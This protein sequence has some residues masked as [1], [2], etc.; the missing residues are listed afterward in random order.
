MKK[1]FD[2]ADKKTL[3]AFAHVAWGHK[4]EVYLMGFIA[5]SAI[6]INVLV[7]FATS[8]VLANLAKQEGQHWTYVYFFIAAAITGIVTNRIGFGA[9]MRIAAKGGRDLDRKVL[10]MLLK[11]SVG[12]HANNIGGKLVSD[13][14][15]YSRSYM[16]VQNAIIIDLVPFAISILIGI[17]I[18]AFSSVALAGIML[19]MSC[20]II[21]W[22]WWT[23]VSRADLRVRRK[24]AQREV[25][26][27][28]GDNIT[29]VFTVKSFANEQ[30]ELKQHTKLGD[31]LFSIRVKDWMEVARDGSNRHAALLTM[32]LLFVLYL[33]HA[34]STN[35]DLLGVSIFAF[36]YSVT[37]TNRL[38]QINTIVQHL[39][40]GLMEAA[41]MT[42]YLEQTIEIIDDPNATSLTVDQAEIQF[43]NVNFQ[44]AD[45]NSAT[46]IFSNFTL[47]IKPGERIGL[48]GPSGGGKSTFMKLLLR[49][50]E[51]TSGTITIDGQDITKVS[52]ESLR[53]SL[54]YVSQEPLLFHR[55]VAEN[56]AYASNGTD[57]DSIRHAA[58]KAHALDFIDSLSNG[59]ETV[60]GERG[61]KL[62]GGQ[63][64]RIAIARTVLKDAPILL[65][66][67]A[68]SAL[69]SE[70][71]KHIQAALHDLMKNKT[72]VVIAHRLSTINQ[73]DR[74]I[75]IDNGRIIEEGTHSQLLKKQGLYAKLWAHQSGG[76]IEDEPAVR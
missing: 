9:L 49:F 13:A 26:A 60:V 8:N 6:C 30:A 46:D 28:I 2:Q 27:H 19:A 23:S 55:T 62:S 12:F 7:P 50:E 76:F 69:D 10:D 53:K 43:S 63:R 34:T 1:L 14:I 67:E 45:N 5:V 16:Q 74:I 11:R 66:D 40:N 32:Q 29:N 65:L 17:G 68:T 47:T 56:I 41:P 52:Q 21:C 4:R 71:E 48:V 54:G 75:V 15:D 20:L 33:V 59:F 72:T 64:Q 36:A 37:M 35:P 38:F 18:I 22:A 51:P 73:L 25:T 44:Y 58:A 57:E 24:T 3:K 70:S 61:V 42:E 39:E 31:K